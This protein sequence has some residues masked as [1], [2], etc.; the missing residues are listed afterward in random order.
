MGIIQDRWKDE[1]SRIEDGIFF[2]SDEC[3]ALAGTPETGYTIGV[4]Q[5]IAAFIAPNPDDWSALIETVTARDKIGDLSIHAGE[6][7]WEGEGFIA[8]VTASTGQL[9]WLFHLSSSEPFVEVVV[10]GEV[11]R[12]VSGGYPSRYEWTIPIYT[13]ERFTVVTRPAA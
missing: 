13:P 8:V 2:G 5:P 10:D 12:A 7:S 1:Q 6:T 3:V 4:R 11:I 9:L